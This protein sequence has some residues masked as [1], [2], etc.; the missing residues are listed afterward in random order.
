MSVVCV[1]CGRDEVYGWEGWRFGDVE[2]YFR[3]AA[4]GRTL[5]VESGDEKRGW[6]WTSDGEGSCGEWAERA[7]DPSRHGLHDVAD[8]QA[9]LARSVCCMHPARCTGI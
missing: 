4:H 9:C 1:G 5:V 2:G 6:G 7:A 3:G 8:F